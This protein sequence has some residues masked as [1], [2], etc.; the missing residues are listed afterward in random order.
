MMVKMITT[1]GMEILLSRCSATSTIRA[2]I[3]VSLN[4]LMQLKFSWR[5]GTA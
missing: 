3:N 1:L 5:S 4:D 2:I